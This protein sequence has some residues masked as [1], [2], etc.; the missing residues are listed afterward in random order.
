MSAVAG[1][2]RWTKI[3]P[4]GAN[5]VALMIDPSAPSTV[6]AGTQGSG[7]LKT[8]DGGASWA[9]INVGLPAT[10][11][12]ALVID[13][14]TSSTLYAATDAG[15][16]KSTNG[17]Q[18]WAGV[19]A[20]LNGAVNALAIDPGTP[21]ILY[22]GTSSGVFKTTDGATNWTSTGLEGLPTYVVTVDPTSP[23]IV[24]AGVA[25]IENCLDDVVF[26]STDNGTSWQR[27]YQSPWYGECASP[28]TAL[29]IDPRSPSRLY[30]VLVGGGLATSGDGGVTWSDIEPNF[31]FVSSLGVDPASS[32]VYVST[33]AGAFYRSID[34]GETWA[35]VTGGPRAINVFAMAAAAPAMIYV[36]GD[37]GIYRS[38]D[39]AQNWTRL[40]LGVRD[41]AVGRPA[42]DITRSSGLAV[43]PTA[44]STIYAILGGGVTKTIDGGANWADLSLG[45]NVD[46]SAIVID[47]ISPSTLYA[48]DSTFGLFKSTDA[49]AHWAPA[50]GT[51]AIAPWVLAMA[52]SRPSILYVGQAA[53]ILK[54]TDAGSTWSDVTNRL[55]ASYISALAVDPTIADTVYVATRGDAYVRVGGLFKSTDG[56]ANWRQLPFDVPWYRS[57]WSLII[58]P[59]TPSTV[60]AVTDDRP[61]VFKSSDGGET[62]RVASSG[63][64][65]VWVWTLAIDPSSP[66]RVYAVTQAGVFR[67]VDGAM[68]WKPMNSGL[69]SLD[70][71]DLSVDRT[72]SRV[73]ATTAAGLFEYSFAPTPTTTTLTSSLNP[74]T[75]GQAVTFTATVGPS[76]T[77]SVNF[78]DGG[79]IIGG[80][81]AVR[82]VSGQAQ[83]TTSALGAGA[84]SIV[85]RYSG[86]GNNAASQSA[87]LSQVVNGVA[88]ASINVALAANGGVASASSAFNPSFP[89]SAVNDGERAG[90]KFSAGGVW[91]DSTFAKF[92]DRVEIAF[93][94]P[95]TINRVVLYSVQDNNINP[96][97]PTDTMT[98]T[99]RGITAFDV[100]A[101]SGSAWVTF[102]SVTGNNLVKRTV[103]FPAISTSKIRIVIKA[104]AGGWYSFL[105]EIEAWTP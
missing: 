40:I 79:S 26:K 89:V 55:T 23:S 24:Y 72:G 19:N 63:L 38:V 59:V 34:A 70:V 30:L 64:P 93:R 50:S 85:A 6:V 92:P 15:V 45:L 3:G 29:V 35:S 11:V 95:Q 10:N 31:G 74:S 81:T 5:V 51:T 68:N 37:T 54:S 48:G 56:A 41:V 77:G 94:V 33:A 73:R 88:G 105:T 20:G 96:V 76:T 75:A 9:A 86:D 101:W 91:K 46:V 28:I 43:D 90:L 58:D 32:A 97:E 53:D 47:P 61:G 22:A 80:C 2:G 17:G 1:V 57:L 83:C 103:S 36:G 60:Y 99:K 12:T 49:G 18:S 8:T 87:L 21:G 100:Q 13:P 62:W 14:V 71:S 27:N 25:D 104:S 78:L 52:P 67:S 98:F 69:P 84:H 66:L 65:Q 82:L 102:G 44:S 42:T 4:D 7:I 16:F 39:G